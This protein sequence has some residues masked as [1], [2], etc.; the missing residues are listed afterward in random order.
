FYGLFRLFVESDR[1][2]PLDYETLEAGEAFALVLDG[3]GLDALADHLATLPRDTVESFID[4]LLER[5]GD[6]DAG[7]PRRVSVAGFMER[8]VHRRI[9][10]LE[11]EERR[12]VPPKWERWGFAQRRRHVVGNVY[13]GGTQIGFGEKLRGLRSSLIEQWLAEQEQ[14]HSQDVDKRA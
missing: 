11:L 2:D 13:K 1:Y 6:R 12:W 14:A 5:A 9:E 4:A 3:S 8:A 10:E 7:Y